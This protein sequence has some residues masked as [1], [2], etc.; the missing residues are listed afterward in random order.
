MR[1]S[2]LFL[3]IIVAL[4]FSCAKT[5]KEIN[6][7]FGQEE[8][9]I[10]VFYSDLLSD[11][12]ELNGCVKKIIVEDRSYDENYRTKSTYF[13]SQCGNLNYEEEIVIKNNGERISRKVVKYNSHG[14]KDCQ[15]EYR[16]SIY[17]SCLLYDYDAKNRLIGI[18]TYQFK[19]GK[20]I[21]TNREYNDDDLL[22]AEICHDFDAKKTNNSI[23]KYNDHGLEVEFTEYDSIDS[24]ESSSKSIYD[25]NYNLVSKNWSY[26]FGSYSSHS[27]E[28]DSL[29]RL[30]YYKFETVLY[31]SWYG[32]E[33]E[34]YKDGMIKSE[35]IKDRYN[36]FNYKMDYIYD[37]NKHNVQTIVYDDDAKCFYKISEIQNNLEGDPQIE[38]TFN[39][40]GDTITK[41]VY[42]YKFDDQGNWI[43]KLQVNKEDTCSVVTKNIKYY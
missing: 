15:M 21:I 28:Y 40:N 13:L 24:I 5:E 3:T 39:S 4:L 20:S 8:S 2:F 34:Y 43:Q 9:V 1:N 35:T 31:S 25:S 10:T 12:I 41:M 7:K 22:I 26:R 29:D 30:V 42:L 19:N 16:N 36:G 17:E 33:Y 11:T 37:E 23:W 18:W 32:I 27:Y 38:F 6:Q 14:N